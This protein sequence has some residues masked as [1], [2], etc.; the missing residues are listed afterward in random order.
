M[1]KKRRYSRKEEE[2][3]IQK[4]H[5]MQR[6]EKKVFL[7]KKISIHHLTPKEKLLKLTIIIISHNDKF[8][9]ARSSFLL[10]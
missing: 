3:L 8:W 4:V 1:K 6:R 5:S 7:E 9:N 10:W 2:S